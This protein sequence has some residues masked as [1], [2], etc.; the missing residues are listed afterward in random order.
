MIIMIHGT[1]DL[2]I[3]SYNDI[4]VFVSDFERDYS[5]IYLHHVV[6]HLLNYKRMLMKSLYQK[7]VMVDCK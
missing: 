2:N 6:K 7:Q 1:L 3:I 5:N 4:S